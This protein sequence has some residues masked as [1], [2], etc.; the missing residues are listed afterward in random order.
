MKINHLKFLAIIGFAVLLFVTVSFEP[1]RYF[2]AE[3][4]QKDIAT[5][6]KT[7]CNACHKAKADKAFDPSKTDEQLTEVVLKGKKDAKPPMPAFETKGVTAEQALALV[8]HM[9]NLRTA[10]AANTKKKE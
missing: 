7:K 10:A 6:Y 4:S 5:V 8:T 2:T 3:G 1:T 9:R